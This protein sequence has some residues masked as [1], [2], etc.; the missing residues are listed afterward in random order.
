[1]CSRELKNYLEAC[2]AMS[3]V[4]GESTARNMTGDIRSN[5]E[6]NFSES[7]GNFFEMLRTNLAWWHN[8]KSRISREWLWASHEEGGQPKKKKKKSRWK[9]C[10]LQKNP[11]KQWEKSLQGSFTLASFQD[12]QKSFCLIMICLSPEKPISRSHIQSVM[13]PQ[14]SKWLSFTGINPKK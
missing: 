4:P 11:V 2:V 9:T 14:G 5:T 6:Q 3:G 1:M 12:S 13:S 8:V 10:S 7:I